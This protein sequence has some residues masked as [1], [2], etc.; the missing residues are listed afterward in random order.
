MA[1]L[2]LAFSDIYTAVSDFLGYST[3]DATE[4]ATVKSIVYRAYRQFLMPLNPKTG[5]I[6][7]WSFLKKTATIT[8]S[9]NNWKYAL[10]D[11]FREI[12]GKIYFSSSDGYSPLFKINRQD[13][14]Q[15]KVTN[16]STTIP[17]VFAVVNS[18]YDMTTGSSYELWLDPVPSGTWTLHYTYV[19]YPPKPE[20]TTDKVIGGPLAQEALLELCLAIAEQSEDDLQTRHHTDL[21]GQLLAQLLLQ[22]L[23]TDTA[24]YG[25]VIHDPGMISEDN[26]PISKDATLTAYDTS[27]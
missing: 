18:D 1:T 5:G 19:F 17:E 24:D 27:I 4:L 15:R 3:S 11:D 13:I 9:D 21:S 22:D 12:V 14:L 25:P 7:T 6:H 2:D 8:T 26:Y 20:S 23:G 10:P 16:N